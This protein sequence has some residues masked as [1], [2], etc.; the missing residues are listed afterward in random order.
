[1]V[2]NHRCVTEYS[3]NTIVKRLSS[4]F[5]RFI[6]LNFQLWNSGFGISLSL[7]SGALNGDKINA[8]MYY[9]LSQTRSLIFE[10]A[11]PQDEKTKLEKLLY[12]P[13]RCYAEHH[14][15]WVIVLLR[16]L[17]H[18]VGHCV[19]MKNITHVSIMWHTVGHCVITKIVTH[20]GSLCY[21]EYCY[22]LWVIVLLWRILHMLG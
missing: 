16:R 2:L 18:T 13:D 1:M 7:A 5:C 15:L 12:Y 21:N 17:L 14:T 6:C 8:T 19:I 11:C 3:V 9:V 20:C 10:I 22:T 4:H